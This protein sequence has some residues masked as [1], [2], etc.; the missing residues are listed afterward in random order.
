MEKKY[1]DYKLLTKLFF[2]LLPYQALMLVINTLNSIVDSLFASNLVG[3]TAMTAIGLYAPATH[4]LFALS[5][6]LVS[7]SQLLTGESLGN[8]DRDRVKVLFS[9][10]ILTAFIIS[11]TVGILLVIAANAGI[12]GLMVD[13]VDER[14]ALKYYMLGQSIGIPA[15]VVGQ[16]LFSF[17]S[18]ENQTKRTMVASLSCVAANTLMNYIFV[19][20]LKLGTFGLGLGSSGGLW[21]FCTVMGL[22]YLT[23]RSYIRFSFSGISFTDIIQIFIKGYSGAI[24]RFVEMFRCIIVNMLIV[25]YVG[26]EGLSSFAA[27]NSVMALF[28]PIPF[29]MTAVTR[30]LLGV[31]IGEK[32]KKSVIDI[33]KIIF[34]K[35]T[36][37]QCG[38][39]LFI[40]V[41]AE[42]ITRLFYRDP[43]NVVYGMTV[44]AFRILPL[45]MPLAVISLAFVTYSQ[46]MDNKK[47][48]NVLAVVDGAVNVV[49]LSLFLIP[50][51]K[52]NGLYI[53]NV[54]NGVICL[55]LIVGF[56]F[57]KNGHFPRNMEQLLTIPEGFGA[58]GD[59]RID[60]EVNEMS[61]VLNVSSQVIDFCKSRGIDD[62]RAHFAGLAL[63]EMAGNIVTHGFT[64]DSGKHYIDIRVI[65]DN[66]D[67]ILRLRD[68]CRS[69]DPLE[70]T[71]VIDSEDKTKNVGIRIVNGISKDVQY[72]NLLGMNVLTIR[73]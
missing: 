43:S 19:A 31:S 14:Q 63:E 37:F 39:S 72:Q 69:F 18:M 40:M 45:C 28:W 67:V 50:A 57:A 54:L 68:N 42:P 16:Q 24:S 60:I 41:L 32:D 36:L 66:D 33:M 5:V 55:A 23:G 47:I 46:S 6:V 62:R 7:G 56:S 22:Y 61:D 11:V 35:A 49:V 38:I 26:N 17:L 71:K 29:G 10:D 21:V 70:R 52:M 1:S 73:I 4:F 8:N 58:S 64:S 25:R 12:A 2:T 65:H 20:K 59:E 48:A 13:G 34:K 51:L 15:L 9:E 53:A 3:E 27:S 44:M 30:M